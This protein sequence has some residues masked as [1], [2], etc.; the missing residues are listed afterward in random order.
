MQETI[1]T[2]PRAAVYSWCKTKRDK[3]AIEWLYTFC[4]INGLWPT[5]YLDKSIPTEGQPPAWTRLCQDVDAGKY[6]VVLSWPEAQG[7]TEWC[8]AR[9]VRFAQ[10]D[11]F[12]FAR[13][14]KDSAYLR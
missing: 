7:M 8:Q 12:E 4:I 6:A 1:D 9:G 5:F 2:R 13:S 3:R 10:V 14:M 11:P